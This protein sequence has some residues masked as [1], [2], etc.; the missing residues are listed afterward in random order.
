MTVV[1]VQMCRIDGCDDPYSPVPG[2]PERPMRIALSPDARR[3]AYPTNGY[4]LGLLDIDSGSHSELV[5]DGVIDL[6][7]AGR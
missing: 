1:G 7:K 4:A 3:V 5:V 2:Y 6:P